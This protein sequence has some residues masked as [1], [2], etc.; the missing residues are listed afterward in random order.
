MCARPPL[1]G[2][3][4][5]CDGEKTIDPCP[6]NDLCPH[7][8][9]AGTA[10]VAVAGLL[11][12]LKITKNKLSDH[13]FVFQGAGEVRA[14]RVSAVVVD[15]EG[16]PSD[17]RLRDPFSSLFVCQ[18]ALGIAHLL[19]MAMA[20]EGVSREDAARRIWMVDS[21]GLIVK[22]IRLLMSSP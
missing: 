11:A 18:A 19:M 4:A 5:A 16:R 12:A 3:V 8:C 2:S 20:K 1:I 13:T 9:L 15:L 14:A 7:P 21:R 6:K 22:V 17:S 10:S